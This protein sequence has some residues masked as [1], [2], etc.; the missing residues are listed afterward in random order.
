MKVHHHASRALWQLTG[1]RLGSRS[2]GFHPAN[3]SSEEE[4]RIHLVPDFLSPSFPPGHPGFYQQITGA[5]SSQ[6]SGRMPH[7]QQQPRGFSG[8]ERGRSTSEAADLA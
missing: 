5:E 7:R 3:F 4:E 2:S 8:E 1:G 6:A